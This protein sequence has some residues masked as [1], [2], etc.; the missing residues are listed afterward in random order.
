MA[1][2]DNVNYT[3]YHDTLG[4]DKVPNAAAFDAGKL[5][6]IQYVKGLLNDGLIAERE[7]GGIDN[8]CC[9]M[10]ESDYTAAQ[11]AAG[12]YNVDTSE[13]IGAYS[14][15]MSAKAAEIAAEKNT[16][17]AAEMRTKWLE[18]FCYVLTGRR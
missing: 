11:T 8:A 6:V 12:A 1:L 3:Y 18:L 4:R 9:M 13:T 15:S 17:S 2:F 5:E 7:P 10:I 16:K 14:H